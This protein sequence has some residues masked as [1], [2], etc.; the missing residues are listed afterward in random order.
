MKVD[1]NKLWKKYYPKLSPK[2]AHAELMQRFPELEKNIEV[3][4][5]E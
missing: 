4:E 1:W 5:N 3:K 2:E